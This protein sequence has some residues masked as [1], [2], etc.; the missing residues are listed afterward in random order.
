M[1]QHGNQKELLCLVL[2]RT[3]YSPLSFLEPSS[4]HGQNRSFF[5]RGVDF[6]GTG[7]LRHQGTGLPNVHQ[8]SIRFVQK[9]QPVL[10]GTEKREE[11]AR[12]GCSMNQNMNI[13]GRG[14]TPMVPF[15]GRRIHHPF[16]Y[17]LVG[18]GMFTAGT[19]LGF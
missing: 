8:E 12:V 11:F 18:I 3:I 1:A 16:W 13:Y 19:G 17:I 6:K 9:H 4:G 10:S 15:W 5:I 14:S 2:G 7:G